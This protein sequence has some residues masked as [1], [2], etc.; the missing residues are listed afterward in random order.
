[1][2]IKSRIALY[3]AIEKLRERPLIVYVT[4]PRMNAAGRMGGD[5]MPEMCDQISA[6]PTGCK[7]VD[8][9]IVSGGGDPMVAWRTISMLRE[10]VE[11]ISVLVPHTAYSAATLLT[12]GADDIIMH[13]FANLGPIDPQIDI[14]RK[15]K[16]GKIEDVHFGSEDME[17]FLDFAR[18]RV[19][20]SDQANM[21]E[22]FKLFCAEAGSISIGIATRSSQLAM[23]LGTKL[24]QMRRTKGKDDRKAKE[25][26]DRLNRQYFNH[27]YALGRH[28]AKEIGLKVIYPSAQ[29]EKTMWELWIEIEENLKARK[30]FDPMSIVS[31]DPRSAGVFT[32]PPSLVIPSNTPPDVVQ[33][34]WQKALSSPL[35]RYPEIDYEI[36]F[37]LL[38]SSR[39]QRMFVEK[40]KL[41]AFI[42]PAGITVNQTKLSSNW[43]NS[44]DSASC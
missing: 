39:V 19:G 32:P 16:D 5:V 18:K 34:I 21:L 17:G 9:L 13:P 2:S 15:G 37:A 44:I 24:L 12:L 7:K 1:M 31:A 6:L 25:I 23:Q 4:S 28:E 3:Q 42:G 36:P 30:P 38:E 10:K 22:A 26:V 33:Q 8:L 11:E 20:L 29:L 40:G 27:G 35:V 43:S 14:K 41:A